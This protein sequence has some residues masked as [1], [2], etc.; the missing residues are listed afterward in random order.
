MNAELQQMC[1]SLKKWEAILFSQIPRQLVKYYNSE[2]E[3]YLDDSNLT[4]ATANNVAAWI[5]VKHASFRI[6]NFF[7][8]EYAD[9]TGQMR[10]ALDWSSV[11]PVTTMAEYFDNTPV[12]DEGD[13]E[14][15]GYMEYMA[16]Y[17]C[18]KKVHASQAK[19]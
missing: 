12:P 13:A 15:D 16:E 10:D 2:K 14:Y 3:E 18:A 17:E 19:V 7:E 8:E 9:F 6:Q 1:L 5:I 4:R 11:H